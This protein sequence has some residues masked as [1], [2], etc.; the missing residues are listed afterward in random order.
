M[1]AQRG[2]IFDWDGVLVDSHDQHER[3]WRQFAGDCGIELPASF[4]KDT[5]GMRNE[6]ILP[7]LGLAE[8][9][10]R[11]RIATLALR[12][13]TIYRELAQREGLPPLPGVRSFLAA[14]ADAGVPCVIGSSAPRDNIT[15]VLEREGL[16]EAFVDLVAAEDV[17]R[18][19]PDP[20]VFVRCAQR[21][22][23]P[24]ERCAVFEDAL[25]GVAAARAAGCVVVAVTNTHPAASF[26][27]VDHVLDGLQGMDAARFA[28]LFDAGPLS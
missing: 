10:D 11:D 2:A 22:G 17:E 26:T 16:R 3:A 7:Y 5:F 25:V 28:R 13:E 27:D 8:P 24:P 20:E 15:P 6:G 21:I 9:G 1:S 18:G 23:L 4:I 14:L 12:K 19:K